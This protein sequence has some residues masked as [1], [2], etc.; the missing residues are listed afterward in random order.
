LPFD[1]ELGHD[2]GM[3]RPLRIEYPGAMDHV[4]ARGNQG[5]AILEE[6]QDRQRFVV[7]L[8]ETCGETGWRVHACGLRNNHYHP[9]AKPPQGNLVAEMKWLQGRYTQR[10]TER[11]PGNGPLQQCRS[12]A[13]ENAGGR[14]AQ[15][16]KSP[17]TTGR[18]R[19]K[20]MTEI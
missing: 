19:R 10:C 18:H 14:R 16:E 8:G 6:D 20:N 12:G 1:L 17:V 9:L 7:A 4:M 15:S 13:P 11:A 2:G 3:V 5:R